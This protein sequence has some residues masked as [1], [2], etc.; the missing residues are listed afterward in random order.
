MPPGRHNPGIGGRLISGIA[1]G[2]IPESVG[3]FAGILKERT[4]I[5]F[6]DHEQV[7]LGIK[8]R[9]APGEI[10]VKGLI[11]V[12]QSLV[13]FTP[14]LPA[15]IELWC[16]W[17]TKALQLSSTAGIP[18]RKTRWLRQFSTPGMPPREIT[19][20][21]QEVQR[22][23]EGLPATGCNVEL[24]RIRDNDGKAWWSLGFE[25]FGELACV[26]DALRSTIDVMQEAKSSAASHLD[27]TQA[28]PNGLHAFTVSWFCGRG[29]LS[30]SSDF[31]ITNSIDVLS[32]VVD[33]Q[34]HP[35]SRTENSN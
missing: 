5:Y 31:T 10:E 32:L 20:R 29:N 23:E 30:Q 14:N 26:E 24:T 3:G 22:R 35:W 6:F 28:I 1:G 15:K 34:C 19:L 16:K 13:S 21:E 9:N 33:R 25:A 12:S 27:T 11:Q 18:I 8:M 4:D 17:K 7:E 2:L